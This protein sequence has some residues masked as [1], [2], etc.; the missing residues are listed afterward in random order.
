MVSSLPI[1]Q[2]Y[3]T[4]TPCCIVLLSIPHLSVWTKEFFFSILKSVQ[5]SVLVFNNQPMLVVE[6]IVS[7]KMCTVTSRD[8][9]SS[10]QC[11]LFTLVF[12]PC[13]ILALKYD[14]V[15][16]QT[17]KVSGT[18]FHGI[19]SFPK[20]LN[21]YI[22]SEK[23]ICVT[24]H[25]LLFHMSLF[26]MARKILMLLLLFWSVPSEHQHNFVNTTWALLRRGFYLLLLDLYQF[27]FLSDF[28]L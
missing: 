3:K 28:A 15:L 25:C 13:I 23:S 11:F 16:I 21:F 4:L 20:M 5:V 14:K 10:I 2:V 24:A 27:V 1:L 9:S 12:A 19:K 6:S 18:A 26:S 8:D 22:L 17:D 7:Y